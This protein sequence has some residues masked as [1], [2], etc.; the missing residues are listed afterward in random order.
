M[1]TIAGATWGNHSGARMLDL[2][3]ASGGGPAL[4][5]LL[6]VPD[7]SSLATVETS[8][9]KEG[10]QPFLASVKTG[11]KVDV[12]LPKFEVGTSFDLTPTL[13]AL[14]MK[15]AFSDGADFSGM[16]KVPTSISAVIHKAWAKV[17]ENGTEAAAAT[18]VVMLETTAVA[19]AMPP[20]PFAVDRSFLFFI[21]DQEGNV[22]FGGRIVDP[23]AH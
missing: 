7:G 11:G 16:S 5:M 4:A 3:Y 6:V 2:P 20:H 1:R 10:I 14:G 22:L 19:I 8:Y 17:D 23:S 18:A 9:A 21:H 15:L 13:G 12:A